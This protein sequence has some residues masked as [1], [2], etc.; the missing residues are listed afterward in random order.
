M[1]KP[2]HEQCLVCSCLCSEVTGLWEVSRA[3]SVEVES[4]VI[5]GLPYYA[6]VRRTQKAAAAQG[7]LSCTFPQERSGLSLRRVGLSV[8]LSVE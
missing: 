6:G 1:R 4:C 8:C 2:T 5:L 3:R 7:C